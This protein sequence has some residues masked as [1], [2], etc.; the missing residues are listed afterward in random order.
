MGANEDQS[1]QFPGLMTV[2]VDLLINT[3]LPH[4]STACVL[5]QQSLAGA[6]ETY[7]AYLFAATGNGAGTIYETADKAQNASS[8]TGK[9]A[10]LR[11]YHGNN[12]RWHQPS[13]A[14]AEPR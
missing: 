5:W 9:P 7:Q 8:V 13:F 10:K 4:R 1:R 11:R 6:K 12:H 2:T 14:T 3:L